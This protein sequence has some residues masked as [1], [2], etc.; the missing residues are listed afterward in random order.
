MLKEF[1]IHFNEKELNNL[2]SRLDSTR[3]PS[4]LKSETWDLGTDSDY[5]TTLLT[6]G[7]MITTGIARNGSLIGIRSLPV[8]WMV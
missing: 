6:I 1:H 3:L 7:A 5:L 4:A 8:N 2:R